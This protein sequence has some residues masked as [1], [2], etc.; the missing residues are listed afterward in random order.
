MKKENEL[1]YEQMN[2]EEQLVHLNHVKHIF[3]EEK[4]STE[5]QRVL[6][7]INNSSNKND[8][9]WT[10]KHAYSVLNLLQTQ[11][12]TFIGSNPEILESFV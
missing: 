6:D 10:P 7:Q 12:E 4:L 8:G 1:S 11:E 5:V 3:S 9:F 2:V